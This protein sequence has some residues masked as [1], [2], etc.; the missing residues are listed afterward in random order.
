M[1]WY[2]TEIKPFSSGGGAGTMALQLPL[3]GAVAAARR[4]PREGERW[5]YA[6]AV[7]CVHPPGNPSGRWRVQSLWSLPALRA[8][9]GNFAWRV[10]SRRRAVVWS[11]AFAR[12]L[13]HGLAPWPR[14][15]ALSL[16]VWTGEWSGLPTWFR[17]LYLEGGVLHVLALSGQH[18]VLLAWWLRWAL[19]LLL[20]CLPGV[21]LPT[22]ARWAN[23]FCVVLPAMVGSCLLLTSGG[24]GSVQRAFFAAA[25][26]A[27]A[28]KLAVPCNPERS[29]L[30]GL[31]VWVVCLP[32]SFWDRSWIL[33]A[34]AAWLLALVRTA[35]TGFSL[36]KRGVAL[37]L[38]VPLLL[39][40]LS[41]FFFGRAA[42]LS[43]LYGI[44]L[45]PL[46]EWCLIP[47]GFV[48]PLA[49]WLPQPLGHSLLAAGEVFLRRVVAWHAAVPPDFA[50][51]YAL[52]Y[53][54]TVWELLLYFFVLRS[55][56]LRGRR[57]ALSGPD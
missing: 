35:S 26:A 11:D 37:A 7:Y 40:P 21:A 16:G 30:W 46:W 38:G 50:G 28:Q 45:T 41:L 36:P 44:V 33:S 32:Q 49:L 29:L 52:G 1:G 34:S 56:L 6:G 12:V 57:G 31:A 48:A 39:L 13:R 22:R 27:V 15:A 23:R 18:V 51:A 3:R 8:E 42:Y 53:V 9:S 5:V 19:I 47:F 24:V 14:I 4:L 10:G 25:V 43:P 17:H 2:L 20:W 55:A 54:P